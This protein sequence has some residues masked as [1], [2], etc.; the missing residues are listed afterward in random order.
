MNPETLR[1]F[2]QSWAV[3]AMAQRELDSAA[4]AW[5]LLIDAVNETDQ[6]CL[7]ECDSIAHAER[8]P[9]IDR[10]AWMVKQQATIVD[11]R[12][13]LEEAE[14]ATERVRETGQALLDDANKRL[15]EAEKALRIIAL[16]TNEM[17]ADGQFTAGD[18]YYAQ[19]IA[20]AALAPDD[21]RDAGESRKSRRP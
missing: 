5:Q 19:A 1:E 12:K 20:K 15:E 10:A 18:A 14:A 3:S 6:P 11:L 13:R 9:H 2:Y 16:M 8:C 7:P 21:S 17:S 4:D